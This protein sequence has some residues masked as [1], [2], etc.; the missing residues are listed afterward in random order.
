VAGPPSR[1]GARALRFA[2][3]ADELHGLAQYDAA[4]SAVHSSTEQKSFSREH[5]RLADLS[6]AAPKGI[7][8]RIRRDGRFVTGFVGYEFRKL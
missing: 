6:G 2:V 7:L 8:A 5:P 1:T 3:G 4:R